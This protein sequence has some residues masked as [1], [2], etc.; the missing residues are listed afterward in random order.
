MQQ[1]RLNNGGLYRIY[2]S[3]P[4]ETGFVEGVYD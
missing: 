2:L 3:H 1:T 4:A